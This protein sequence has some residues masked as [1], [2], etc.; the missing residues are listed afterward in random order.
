MGTEYILR[1]TGFFQRVASG[2]SHE[3][4]ETDIKNGIPVMNKI[5]FIVLIACLSLVSPAVN[6]AI[7]S[8]EVECLHVYR[9]CLSS[10]D[11]GTDG[12]GCRM[13]CDGEFETCWA[14]R[15]SGSS[16]NPSKKHYAVTIVLKNGG[17]VEAEK[18]WADGPNTLKVQTAPG[19]VFTMQ[20][21]DVMGIIHEPGEPATHGDTDSSEEKTAGGISN[22]QI[23]AV[24]DL[25]YGTYK[26]GYH[27][28]ATMEMGAALD[29]I[30]REF[31]S[32]GATE[33]EVKF[34]LT[35]AQLGYQFA[36]SGIEMWSKDEFLSYLDKRGVNIRS[37]A[38]Q[39]K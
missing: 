20:M 11:E 34:A 29:V 36:E 8:G 4:I 31:V 26:A 3:D 24:V 9:N 13:R 30:N 19:S 1:S 37:I 28:Q 27:A 33:V 22:E 5:L 14:G 10:C 16:E 32:A 21:T 2:C 35:F 38:S 7:G 23:E 18:A 39:I 15:Q 25:S 12:D 6:S 17:T